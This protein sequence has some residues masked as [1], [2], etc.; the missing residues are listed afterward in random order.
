MW[1]VAADNS[2]DDCDDCLGVPNG[3]HWESDCGCVVADNS[4]DDCD[5]CAGVPNG[6][7]QMAEYW[8][9]NDGDGLG[10]DG[11]TDGCYLEASNCTQAIKDFTVIDHDGYQALNHEYCENNSGTF[12]YMQSLS[13]VLEIGGVILMVD[14]LEDYSSNQMQIQ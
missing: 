4:G 1:C 9:D 2:G 10:F 13:N 7:A 8:I 11:G 5:D 12:E 6:D 3:T 14:I